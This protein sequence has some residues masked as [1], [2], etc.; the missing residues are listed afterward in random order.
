MFANMHTCLEQ[1]EVMDKNK[2]QFGVVFVA[3]D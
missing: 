3:I 1:L 2:D